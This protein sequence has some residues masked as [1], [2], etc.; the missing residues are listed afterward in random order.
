MLYTFT[1][2]LYAFSQQLYHILADFAQHNWTNIFA[3]DIPVG[4]GLF[5]LPVYSL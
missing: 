5:E 1:L 3:Q 4:S 2:T